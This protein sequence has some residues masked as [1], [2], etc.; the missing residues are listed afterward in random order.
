MKR[1]KVETRKRNTII[2]MENLI[3][4]CFHNLRLLAM[5]A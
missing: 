1:V 4:I 5:A 3:N 2:M